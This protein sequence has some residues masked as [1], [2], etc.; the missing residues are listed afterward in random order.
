VL[1]IEVDT[2]KKHVSACH[3]KARHETGGRQARGGLGERASAPTRLFSTKGGMA[4]ETG[5][6]DI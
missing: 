6:D 5:T 1:S 2:V 3:V 4:P